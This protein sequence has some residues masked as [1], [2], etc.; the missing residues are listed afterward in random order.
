MATT[1]I[2]PFK[3]ITGKVRLS[4]VSVF[5]MNDK[6]KYSTAI[7]I[8]KSDK[9]TLDKIKA[10]CELV[11]ADPK[12]STTWGGKFLSSFKMPLR[13]GDTD[14]DVEKSPEYKGHFFMNC[15]TSLKPG[16][17]DAQMNP[18]M[19]KSEV[20]SGCYARVS[21]NM[22]PFNVDGN[23]GIAAGLNNVQKLAEGDTLTGRTRAED[24]F[25]AVEDDF[26]N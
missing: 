16:V 3:V 20:Y 8:P 14:R 10:A 18:I 5:E 19:D 26:L 11:K 22:F 1:I 24:D 9:E 23:K 17:V 25:T 2:N 13:D 15:N 12:A 4:Y 21:I 6:G 7:L